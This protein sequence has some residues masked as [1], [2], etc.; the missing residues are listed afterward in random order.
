MLR[1][2]SCETLSIVS[3]ESLMNGNCSM[4]SSREE[5]NVSR[6]QKDNGDKKDGE[7]SHQTNDGD[8]MNGES[9]EQTGDGDKKNG[10]S[11]KETADGG[12]EAGDS[13]EQSGGGDKKASE[14]AEQ[15]DKKEQE[16]FVIQDT[17][18]TVEIAPPGM[19]PFELPVKKKREI[20]CH[21]DLK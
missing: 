18:F 21:L 17:S 20:V 1:I 6:E 2:Q 3:D 5:R 12:K 8:K 7:S 4:D 13:T 14:S 16:I 15:T 9:T 19:E 11:V 10:E